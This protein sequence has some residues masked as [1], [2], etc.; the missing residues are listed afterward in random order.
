MGRAM[1]FDQLL[2]RLKALDVKVWLDGAQLRVNAPQ[3]ALTDDLKKAL[4]DHKSA[5]IASLSPGS[6]ASAS[7][8]MRIERA[9][10]RSSIPLTLG[11]ERIWSLAKMDP[12]SSTYNVP[13]V[14]GLR[15]KLKRADLEKALNA[16]NARHESLRTRFMEDGQGVVRQNIAPHTHF[17]LKSVDLSRDLAKLDEKQAQSALLGVLEKEVRR[18]FDLTNG[19]VWRSVL[20]RIR[21]GMHVLCMTMHHIVFDGVSRA[22]FLEELG[23]L[24]GAKGESATLEEAPIQ[25]ADFAIWQRE[26]ITADKISQALRFWENTL[27]GAVSSLMTPN[28]RARQP[29]KGRAESVRFTLNAQACAQIDA[30]VKEAKVSAFAFLHAAFNVLLNRY[31]GQS[32]LI[33][34]SPMAN[35]SATELERVVGYFNNIVA[36]RTRI[37]E[38]G[39]FRALL[40]QVRKT[41]IE[42]FDHQ[43]VPLQNVS[44]LP[45]LVKTQLS[46]A[47]ISYQ[48]GQSEALQ[49]EGLKCRPITV[50]KGFADFELALYLERDRDSIVGVLDFNADIFR[51]RGMGLLLNRFGIILN[52][53]LSNPDRKI[54][55]FSRFGRYG[56]DIEKL[57]C[58]HPKV[59]A[60]AI[61]QDSTSGESTAYLV[62][63]E[64]DVPD[65][66]EVRRHLAA[67]L[68]DFR[69][70]TALIP[71]DQFPLREDGSIDFDALPKPGLGRAR[72]RSQYKAPSTDLENRLA[73]IW[74]KVL[75]LDFD[76][77]VDDDFR[78]LGGH[79]LLSV[80]LVHEVEAAISAPLPSRAL[81]DLSTIA[82]LARVIEEGEKD[83]APLDMGPLPANIYRGLRSHTA[84]WAGTRASENSVTV[85]LNVAG[86]RKPL[87]WCLQRYQE[88]TQ[89]AKY[90]GPNQ[91]VYG[92]R[93]GNRVMIKTQDN[94]DLLAS[95][96]VREIRDIQ[97]RGP[98][99]LGGNC[100]AAQI[101]FQIARQMRDAGDEV[102]VL[103]LHEKFIP[104]AYDAPIVMSFGKDSTYN[105]K[106]YFAHP[107][108]GWR[109]FYTGPLVAHEVSGAHGQ[110][111]LEPNVQDLVRVIES[112]LEQ[113]DAGVFHSNVAMDPK[114]R[115]MPVDAYRARIEAALQPSE[116]HADWVRL[117][118]SV[119]NISAHDWPAADESGFH[120]VAAYRTGNGE[121]RRIPGVH[122]PLAAEVPIGSTQNFEFEIALPNDA[123]SIDL[124]LVDDGVAYFAQH[125]SAPCVI[126]IAQREPTLA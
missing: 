3:G 44:M 88:L 40:E 116:P 66:D 99:R 55:E 33:V 35:R 100:Q 78:E 19:P 104:F 102:E 81:S 110:F 76:V 7:S 31:S 105:P 20:F 46:R 4:R 48:E 36:L 93:S 53:A 51:R 123:T 96:Y 115:I 59:D 75:W 72:L 120:L 68:P 52:E 117:T 62:L 8:S 37:D 89:L 41:V 26:A 70:P 94:I 13:A 125:G 42:A 61:Q 114:R 121:A 119:T 21:P 109:K 15:G 29:R 65:L 9:R 107:Q 6:G 47:M 92:M 2:G 56:A 32:D 90:L 101:A 34:C 58:A 73:E 45:N 71:V 98:Y 126:P 83:A 103:F 79:S 25:F 10:D 5:L 18:P 95:F 118:A 30:F 111:F 39:T 97:P 124:D 16:L 69:L 12:G 80:Q 49:L 23:R 106:L 50:R 54:S 108:N 38:G 67:S 77:G 24:Y 87:F 14:F 22:I 64:H 57:L 86:S 1:D 91:P 122:L 84:T 82:H 112:G 60:A 28:Q 11:Q 17:V 63:N 74:K 113:A 27:S 85:G 43:F